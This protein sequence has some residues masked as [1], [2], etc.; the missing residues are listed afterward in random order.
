MK[1]IFGLLYI[2]LGGITGVLPVQAITA[3]EQHVL[4]LLSS[5]RITYSQT[6]LV[7]QATLEDFA[8]TEPETTAQSLSYA[9]ASN[10]A[11]EFYQYATVKNNIYENHKIT[12]IA[13]LMTACYQVYQEQIK[14]QVYKAFNQE[15]FQACKTYLPLFAPFAFQAD[16]LQILVFLSTSNII[17]GMKANTKEKLP[18]NLVPLYQ[19]SKKVDALL[20]RKEMVAIQRRFHFK[21]ELTYID[22]LKQNPESLSQLQNIFQPYKISVLGITE[23]LPSRPKIEQIDARSH[24]MTFYK[25]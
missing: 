18:N 4:N 13:Q 24:H 10:L 14:P 8:A 3:N 23:L 1:L 21:F 11:A 7:L 15:V 6:A 19:F 25:Q 9:L 2:V 16:D 5:H 17:M 22:V 12:E 20:V